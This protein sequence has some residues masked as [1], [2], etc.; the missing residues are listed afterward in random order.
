MSFKKTARGGLGRRRMRFRAHTGSGHDVRADDG[1]SNTGPRPDGARPGR[2]SSCAPRWT[3]SR[4][5]TRSARTTT[6]TWSMPRALQ[7][8]EY[9]QVFTRIDLIH[10]VTGPGRD[11]GGRPPLHRAVGDEVLPG[12]RDAGDGRDRDPPRLPDRRTRAPIPF[13][14]EGEVDRHR[15]ALGA[16]RHVLSVAATRGRTPFCCP[17]A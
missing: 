15:A 3:S 9:P 6:R 11:R 2:R 8:K 14:A 13:T 12:Q 5:S 1:E 4:S 17:V 10:E 7:R 16:D